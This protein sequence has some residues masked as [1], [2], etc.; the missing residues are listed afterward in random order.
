MFS[1]TYDVNDH[2]FIRYSANRSWL[3]GMKVL[4][5]NYEGDVMRLRTNRMN[6]E[7]HEVEINKPQ[8][9]ESAIMPLAPRID[10]MKDTWTNYFVRFPV[11]K[12]K[13]T[14][15]YADMFVIPKGKTVLQGY[16][17]TS[18][19]VHLNDMLR[20]LSYLSQ[21]DFLVATRRQHV[22]RNFLHYIYVTTFR[23]LTNHPENIVDALLLLL[24][25]DKESLYY[26]A[27]YKPL[28]PRRDEHCYPIIVDPQEYTEAKKQA[29]ER[30]MN[31]VRNF[32][33]LNIKGGNE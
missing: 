9:S 22:V 11:H 7:R 12:R 3:A 24:K 14:H 1:L 13:E 26:F 20:Y 4:D 16:S 19:P 27:E 10:K 29:V 6:L 8:Y 32:F 25:K 15:R 2:A 5:I 30:F 31:E 17:I 33:H 23:P 28:F 18:F 21:K